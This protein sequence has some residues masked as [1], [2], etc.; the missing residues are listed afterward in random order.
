MY[1]VYKIINEKIGIPYIGVTSGPLRKRWQAHKSAASRGVD[2]KFYNAV[3]KYGWE[4][5]WI[6][7]LSTHDTIHK[8]YFEEILQIAEHRK[9]GEVYNTLKGGEGIENRIQDKESWK[10]NLRKARKGGTPFKGKHHSL[11]TR[12]KCGEASKKYWE[13]NKYPN[14]I[15]EIPFKEAQE[16]YGISRTHYYRLRKRALTNDQC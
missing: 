9:F 13:S 15:Y 1:I 5:F 3:R 16:K 4:H 2:T 8:A 7:V 10:V 14:N 12:N 6:R 11:E